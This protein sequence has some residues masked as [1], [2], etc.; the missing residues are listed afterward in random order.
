MDCKRS[1]HKGC[2]PGS[3]FRVEILFFPFFG[4]SLFSFG[5]D[6]PCLTVLTGFQGF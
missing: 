3:F 6:L 1:E 5:A 4:S 2:A